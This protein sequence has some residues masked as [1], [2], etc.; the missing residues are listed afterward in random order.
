MAAAAS[1]WDVDPLLSSVCQQGVQRGRWLAPPLAGL[2]LLGRGQLLE[3][4]LIGISTMGAALVGKLQTLP[5]TVRK[6]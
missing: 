5:V 4:K 2:P 6:S 1:V 3:I